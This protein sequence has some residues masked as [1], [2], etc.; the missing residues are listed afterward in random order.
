MHSILE[1]VLVVMLSIA[2]L[3]GE[4]YTPWRRYTGRELSRPAAYTIGVF[5][6]VLPLIGLWSWW[7]INPPAGNPFI[8]CIASLVSVIILSGLTVYALYLVD[9]AHHAEQRARVAEEEAEVWRANDD[10]TGS[11]IG[12]L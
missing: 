6:M 2:M 8:W 11:S 1:M 10:G 3:W 7:S 4:H 9:H 12:Q 5:T